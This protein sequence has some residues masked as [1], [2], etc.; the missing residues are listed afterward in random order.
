MK[1]LKQDNSVKDKS[2]KDQMKTNI[3]KRT[4]F[5]RTNLKNDKSEKKYLKEDKNGKGTSD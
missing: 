5:N 3:W 4:L 2:E 1:H